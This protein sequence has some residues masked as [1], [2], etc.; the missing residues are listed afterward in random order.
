MADTIQALHRFR[1]AFEDF[2]SCLGPLDPVEVRQVVVGD[3]SPADVAAHLAG[4]HRS[5]TE[6]LGRLADGID[7]RDPDGG[8]PSEDEHNARAVAV[9]EGLTREQV[10]DELNE[11]F[12]ACYAAVEGLPPDAPEA[13]GMVA[14]WIEEEAAHY[15]SHTFEL[16]S[17]LMERLTATP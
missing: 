1:L 9:L 15:R 8:E 5:M 3:W 13:A 6:A 4:C 2:A 7:P 14:G 16:R 11:A 12:E 10:A 17:A